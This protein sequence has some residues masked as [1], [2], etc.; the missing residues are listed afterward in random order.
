VNVVELRVLDDPVRACADALLAAARAR[1]RPHI[2]LS[3]GSSPKAAYRH[4]AVVDPGVIGATT[5][6]FGDERC[7]PPDDERS[8]YRM[9]R[10]TL[11][12]PLAAAGVQPICHRMPADGG[13]EAAA[14]VYERLLRDVWPT[15]AP[16]FDLVLLG[17]GPDGHTL[18]LFPGKPEVDER[19]HLVV[20]VPQAGL[21]PF[22]PRVSLTFGALGAAARVIVLAV[23]AGKADVVARVFGSG[24]VPSASIPASMLAQAVAPGA[25]TVLLDRASAAR[26]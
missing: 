4:V 11:L 14:V 18:S 9:A 7:V 26:L 19:E 16:A 1:P 13:A 24:A 10:E 6:W 15:G 5:L 25:L 8:N 22:V 20:P 2:V 21:E 23:G 3:G 17:L 12:D